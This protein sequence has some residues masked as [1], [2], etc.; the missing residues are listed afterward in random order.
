MK[1]RNYI[2]HCE[3]NEKVSQVNIIILCKL[4]EIA[5]VP[6]ANSYWMKWKTMKA[7]EQLWRVAEKNVVT[8]KYKLYKES[9]DAVSLLN[10]QNVP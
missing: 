2:L 7:H 5:L 9:G 6:T 8:K 3:K 1:K 4:S 10:V